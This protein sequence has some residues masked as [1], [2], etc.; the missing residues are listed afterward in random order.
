MRPRGR[1]GR[2][3]LARSRRGAARGEGA[4]EQRQ[5]GGVVAAARGAQRRNGVDRVELGGGGQ[6]RGGSLELAPLR[7]GVELYS[8]SGSRAM[9]R[10]RRK[11]RRA[12]ASSPCCRCAVPRRAEPWRRRARQ[13]RS[14]SDR[15][16]TAPVEVATTR[17]PPPPR[18]PPPRGRA[19]AHARAA[20][21]A[22]PP[23]A[24]EGAGR[25]VAQAG[26]GGKADE[27]AE[28]HRGCT[29]GARRPWCPRPRAGEAGSRGAP[30]STKQLSS[31]AGTEEEAAESG[32]AATRQA[33]GR[34]GGRAVGGGR[35]QRRPRGDGGPAEGGA[36]AR[37]RRVASVG[38]ALHGRY[39]VV[40]V[41]GEVWGQSSSRA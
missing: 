35:A 6:R 34:G 19:S 5:R 27:H 26:C 11:A 31:C 29:A 7:R 22:A 32:A 37:P 10:A 14:V 28:A 40:R 17:A 36:A 23:G 1:G 33:R 9:A 21:A 4:F 41:V 16:R 12:A 15:V 8:A 18:P 39:A 38:D 2:R 30:L 20:A 24:C 3:N 25:A 13:R